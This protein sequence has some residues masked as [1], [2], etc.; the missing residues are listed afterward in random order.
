MEMKKTRN[1]LLFTLLVFMV[2]CL[3]FE[4]P[5]SA[6]TFPSK[7]ITII[8]PWSPGGAADAVSRW[9]ASIGSKYLEQPIIVVNKTGGT[10]QVGHTAGA[11]AKP[12]GYTLT[13]MT[14]DCVIL[15]KMGL[16]KTSYK[17][18]K[19]VMLVTF[20]GAGV[21]VRAD[22]PWKTLDDLIADAKK[23]PRKF[24]VATIGPGGIWTVAAE[25]LEEQA[26]VEFT[27]VPFDGAGPGIVA[28]LGGHVDLATGGVAEAWPQIEAGKLRSLGLMAE[29]RSAFYPNIPTLKE[30]G[31]DVVV[32]AWLALAVPKE[33]PDER[34]KILHDGFKKALDT[35][36]FKSLMDKRTL[37]IVYMGPKQFQAELQRE[38]KFFD[39]LVKPGK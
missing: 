13:M 4:N 12:D 15:P 36:A 10:G 37:D 38:D 20:W 32:G 27:H 30:Q 34:V 33:T 8:C 6:E 26:E 9:L 2:I 31:Y 22:A 7:T 29:K 28:L 14:V 23:H 19:P 16:G 17:A 5:V 39:K 35:E 11:N 3:G 24:K 25:G 1:T 21:Q 18:F